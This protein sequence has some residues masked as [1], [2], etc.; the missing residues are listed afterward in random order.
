MREI[1]KQR[2]AM[3]ESIMSNKVNQQI[4]NTNT[5]INHIENSQQRYRKQQTP[6][7]NNFPFTGLGLTNKK[8]QMAEK[9][10]QN[11]QE[12]THTQ[13][14]NIQLSIVSKKYTSR[15]KI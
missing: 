6:L 9:Q 15:T 10:Q 5:I 1:E 11:K 2:R 13:Q 8:M 14:T 4:E 12:N 7:S 3:E